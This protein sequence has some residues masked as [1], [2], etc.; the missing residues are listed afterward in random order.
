MDRL[1]IAARALQFA[2]SISLAGIFV[3]LCFVAAPQ[4][5]ARLRRR[6]ALLAW[7]SLL[8]VLAS[9][10]AWLLLLAAGMSGKPVAAALSQGAVRIVLTRTRFGQIWLLRLVAA[11][12][13]AV[14]LLARYRSPGPVWRRAGLVLAALML[15]GLA[16][17]GHGGATPG[18]PGD[19]HLAAD[20]LHLLAAGA[21]LGSL[22][23][24][25]LLL[26]EARS[27]G[28]PG[29]A[30]IARRAVRRFSV[31]AAAMV[32]TLFA[33]GLVNTWFL[34]GSV[35]ALIGTGYGRLL[36]A[37]IAIFAT[38]VALAA[39]NLLRMAPR[40]GPAASL[41]QP[42]LWVAV[43]HLRRNAAI[44]AS[45]GLS[46]LA[47]V[48]VLGILPPGLHTEPGWPLPFRLEPGALATGSEIA[49]ALLAGLGCICAAAIVAGAAAGRY[50]RAG[51]AS[52][53]LALCLGVG[54]IVLRPVLEPA[55]P[56]SFYASAEP[57]AAPSVAR[58]ARLYARNCALC[59]GAAGQGDGPAAAGLP[60][61]PADLTAPHLFAHSEGDLFW[62][63]SHGRG[64]GAMPGFAG[65]MSA[66]E[67][68]DTINFIRARAAGALSR[69][70]SAAT[71]GLEIPDFAFAV[72]GVQQTLSGVL[73]S[74]PALLVLFARAVP[75]QR[76]AALAEAAPRLAAAGLRVLAI[77]TG[78]AARESEAGPPPP[79]AVGVSADVAATLALFRAADDGGETDLMLDRAGN[80]RARWTR[81]GP[82]GLADA[83][84]LA[85][86][87]VR[88][89][90]LPAAA[91]SHAGHMH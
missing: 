67:R 52:G 14:C 10:A 77:D 35:P 18:R 31:L 32:A 75:R 37:K 88:V 8:L 1:L 64:D 80:L 25:A 26:S 86:A 42:L 66:A 40:L 2:S 79:L 39:V 57:Y 56:T 11:G 68:W 44:E 72:R 12:L 74:G 7:A 19:L 4:T 36:L 43:A 29:W 90:R 28:D 5:S 30:A 24:L 51:A 23:P 58:G 34:A 87:A 49:L 9:G 22:I 61:R 59:H 6:L 82:G 91:V 27:I 48:G 69:R 71:A 13:L 65:V 3:F 54:C 45:L 33:A 20:M 50:R 89:A 78:A 76:L 85:A 41:R 62:W 21:W 46:V 73:K 55:Y 17:A 16:W 60:V 84:A 47:I 63:V 81:A 53:G 83:E 70:V 15:A 38:M